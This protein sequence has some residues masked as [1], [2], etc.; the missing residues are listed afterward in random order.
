LL[1]QEEPAFP[2]GQTFANFTGMNRG[3]TTQLVGSYSKPNWLIRHHRVTTP[4]NDSTFWRP[5][6]EVLAEAQDAATM[7]AISD[8]ERAGLD[9]VTDGEQRRQRFDSYFFR[10]NGLDTVNLAPWSVKHRDMSFIDLNSELGI[11]LAEAKAP[12]VVGKLSWSGPIVLNDLRFLKRHA[13]RPVKMTVIGPLT[14]ACRLVNEYYPDEEALGMDAAGVINQELKALQSE[15]VDVIQL[16]EPEFHFRLDQAR[17]W[18]T[19]ALDLALEGIRVFTMVHICYGY[20]MIGGKHVDPNYGEA[21]DAIAASRA[22][23]ISLEYEQPGHGPDLLKHCGDKAVVL[24]LL[25]L[26]T[27]TVEKPA[28]IADRIHAALGVVPHDRLHFGPDCGMWFLPREVAFAKMR[29]LVLG[30]E[31]VR[32]ELG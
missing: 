4:Y 18:G 32:N 27:P 8:Q 29:A 14:T 6:P 10:F 15:G 1:Y 21:I 28:Y 24:G 25:N 17:R 12:R 16:D 5:E 23:A 19:K 3:L 30:A 9:I 13:R 11:R 31:I 26:G 2:E 20:A 7:L 22:Q